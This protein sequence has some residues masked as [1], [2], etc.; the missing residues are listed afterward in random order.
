ML[1]D[2]RVNVWLS[3]SESVRGTR[4]FIYL[5]D[6]IFLKSQSLAEFKA[7]LLSGHKREEE[8]VEG[9]GRERAS[10]RESVH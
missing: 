3:D 5:H 1:S 8:E 10:E 2:G 6:M 4:F 9:V 7:S